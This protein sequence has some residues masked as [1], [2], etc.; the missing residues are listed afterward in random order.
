M[1]RVGGSIEERRRHDAVGRNKVEIV[2]AHEVRFEVPKSTVEKIDAKAGEV[3]L[4]VRALGQGRVHIHPFHADNISV[5]SGPAGAKARSKLTV[6]GR[7]GVDKDGV[8]ETG[9]AG[10]AFL[11]EGDEFRFRVGLGGRGGSRVHTPEKVENGGGAVGFFDVF[12]E[13]SFRRRFPD[14]GVSLGEHVLGSKTRGTVGGVNE[15]DMHM[16]KAIKEGDKANEASSLWGSA[17]N[18]LAD[19]V[20]VRVGDEGDRNRREVGGLEKGRGRRR[21]RMSSSLRAV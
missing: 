5:R 7:R 4:Y 19:G 10:L 9:V 3:V 1:W 13:G 14:V 17:S 16:L 18:P 15:K 6:V 21:R 8:E 2:G 12:S 11:G 20:F